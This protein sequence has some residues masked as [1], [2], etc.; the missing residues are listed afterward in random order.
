MA[1]WF[2]VGG[3]DQKVTRERITC[4]CVWGSLHPYHYEEGEKICKHIREVMKIQND[5]RTRNN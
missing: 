4:T 2:E 3:Y 5:K 1:Q